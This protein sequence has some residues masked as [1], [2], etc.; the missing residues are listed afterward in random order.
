M[1][2]PYFHITGQIAMTRDQILEAAKNAPAKVKL[3][4]HREAVEALREKRI[5]LERNC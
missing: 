1:Y 5:H 4:E 2:T 3:E